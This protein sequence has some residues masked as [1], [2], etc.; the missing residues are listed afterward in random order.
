MRLLVTLFLASGC[1]F[2]GEDPYSGRRVA[3]VAPWQDVG[4]LTLCDQTFSL[5]A[6]S[7]SPEGFCGA[8]ST[9]NCKADPDCGSRERCQCGVCTIGY[10]DTSDDCQSGFVCTMSTHRCDKPCQANGD[11]AKNELCVEGRNL[12]RGQCSADGD[13]QNGEFCNLPTGECLS[14]SCSGDSDCTSGCAIQRKP[15]LLS[16]PTPLAE[17]SGVTLWLAREG[18]IVRATSSDGLH[19]SLDPSAVP[20]AGGA[21]SVVSAMGGYVMLLERGADL[22]RS[23]SS[24]GR[25]WSDPQAALP[26]A[27]EPSLVENLDHSF[28]AYVIVD[29]K[30][31]RSDSTDGV[32]FDAPDLVLQPSALEQPTLW[33]NV[34][35]IR[36]PFAQALLDAGGRPFI[37]LWFA[38]RGQESAPALNFN[39]Y[40]EVPANFS[41]GE[42]V[43]PD[44]ASF[45][46]Y[47]FN[48]VFDR[49]VMFIQHPDE[50]EP[51]LVS[52]GDT[53][54]MYYR[55]GD[56]GPIAVAK[57]PPNPR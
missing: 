54:L 29:G 31:A 22:Y 43:A 6:P 47:P 46:P 50:L 39:Q 12:C 38:A 52:L 20:L 4:P 49:V 28:A 57:S 48:P 53:Q 13:C 56:T 55:R 36:S 30:V 8:P 23:F 5:I 3:D 34:D 35:Q 14:T 18:M 41:I 37:R 42:A 17:K 27:S 26:N 24:D 15:A 11:C 45:D 32:S 1:G 10:C 16:E 2:L 25:V 7:A 19:F 21:P 9:K 33:R 51:A 40:Q 44:G